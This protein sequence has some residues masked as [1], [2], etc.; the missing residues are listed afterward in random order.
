MSEGKASFFSKNK[1]KV[2]RRVK[3]EEGARERNKKYSEQ[4]EKEVEFDFHS[5]SGLSSPDTSPKDGKKADEKWMG[6][7][8]P[9]ACGRWSAG[10]INAKAADDRYPRCERGEAN[11]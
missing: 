11:G 10:L 2:V 5:A 7:L 4:R 1:D 8:E 9:L 3:T 6:E